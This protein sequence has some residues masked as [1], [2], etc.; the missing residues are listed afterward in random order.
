MPPLTEGAKQWL[1]FGIGREKG[2]MEETKRDEVGD[3]VREGRGCW[4]CRVRVKKRR[5]G[6]V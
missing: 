3:T 1:C 5:S 2:L 6:Y 4:P